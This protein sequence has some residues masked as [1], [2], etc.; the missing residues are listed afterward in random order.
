M[1]ESHAVSVIGTGQ[2][3]SALA[4]SFLAT[5]H[6]VIVWNRTTAK[7][8]ALRESGA[9]VAET[10]PEAAAASETVVVCLLDY[11]VAD[12]LLRQPDVTSALRGKTVVQL[13]T[14]TA[15]DAR[16]TLRWAEAEGIDYLDGAIFGLPGAEGCRIFCSGPRE[17]FERCRALLAGARGETLHVGEK[18]SDANTIDEAVLIAYEGILFS[19]LQAAAFCDA[20]G[21]PLDRFESMATWLHD[22]YGPH[23]ADVL[24]PVRARSFEVNEETPLSIW[25]AAIAQHVRFAR[26]AGID[27]TFAEAL[28]RIATKAMDAGFADR[29]F[30][31]AYEGFRSS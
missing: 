3:G 8:D 18:I 31:A 19:F 7:A 21:V 2:M 5:G 28:L 27:G 30:S 23:V 22:R 20:E 6:S 29:E 13:T 26:E 25:R 14:G 1:D 24:S 10:L 15:A 11:A 12:P 17:H 4:R 9:T 16:E